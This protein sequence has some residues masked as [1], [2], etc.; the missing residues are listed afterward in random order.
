MTWVNEITNWGITVFSV[1]IL[2]YGMILNVI[3]LVQ[4]AAAYV[5]LR[6]GPPTLPV[7]IL[8]PAY[9]EEP[10]IEESISSLLHVDYPKFEV[11]VIND[12]S[13]DKTLDVLKQAFDLTPSDRLPTSNLPHA[14]YRQV[15]ESGRYSNLLVVDKENGGKAD[16]LNAGINIARY[17]LICPT[18]ADSILESDALQRSTEAFSEDSLTLVVVGGTVRVANGC[19]I[20]EGRV[21]EIGLPT[22]PLAL[23]QS[24]EYI[25][26]FLIGRLGWSQ[27]N[28]LL[29]ISGAF[30][31]FKRD[32]VIASGGYRQDTVGEDIEL[33]VKMHKHMRDAEFDYYVK[34]LPEPVCWTQVPT[35]LAHLGRQRM[36]WQRGALETF[37]K[38]WSMFLQ[39]RYGRVGFLAFLI[40]SSR[41]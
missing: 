37:F 16:A 11:L 33:T 8:S 1:A 23:F 6:Q 30:G 36:R 24:I 40:F 27:L 9:N 32:V 12:G 20:R 21:E 13:S 28:M 7:S 31:V 17:P 29:L 41:M 18:D 2:T 3:Y 26:S 5:A 19:T 38:H 25:R 39:P 34:F 35:R 4:L 15:Y 22:A 10:V 14:P